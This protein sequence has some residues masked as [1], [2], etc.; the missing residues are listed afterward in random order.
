VFA[1]SRESGK[2]ASLPVLVHVRRK[3]LAESANAR[4]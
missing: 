1:V 4:D 2:Q 3:G